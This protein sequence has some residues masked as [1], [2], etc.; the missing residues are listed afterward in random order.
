MEEIYFNTIK[1]VK[2]HIP[3][4]RGEMPKTFPLHRRRQE[5][6]LLPFL[7]N[8]ALE[9]LAKSIRQED[10]KAI[11]VIKDEKWSL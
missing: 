4:L 7:F 6:S 9:V 2:R 8:V 3:I 10:I 11:Q 1:A 5:C